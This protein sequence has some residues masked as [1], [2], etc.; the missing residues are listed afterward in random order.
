MADTADSNH[1]AL[2][3]EL[4]LTRW[5]DKNGV[6]IYR[7]HLGEIHRIHGPAEVRPDGT[8]AWYRNGKLHRTDGAAVIHADGACYWFLQGRELSREK[9]DEAMA[10]TN[11][12][13]SCIRQ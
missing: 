1:A 2:I 10:D 4:C 6:V 11:K 7:N 3:E 13:M 12:M 5:E 8:C 9:F